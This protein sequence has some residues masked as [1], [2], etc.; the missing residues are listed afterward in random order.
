MAD[1][2]T[3]E[4]IS[5]E[6]FEAGTA[7]I[8]ERDSADG[9]RLL[10]Y[11]PAA[12]EAEVRAAIARAASGARISAAEWIAR[13]DW[14]EQ[15]KSGLKAAE[16][17]PRLL[18]RPSFVDA[19]SKP[20]QTQLIIDP[21][22]AFGTGGHPST[23]LLLEWIDALQPALEARNPNWRMLDVGTGTGVLSLAAVSFGA[24]LAFAFDLD[25]L[26]IA[27]TCAN[28]RANDIESGL[29]V[30]IGPLDAVADETFDLVVANLLRT[31]LMP[32]IDGIAA[33]VRPGGYAVFAGLLHDECESVVAAAR[34]TGLS[35]TG[36]RA[37]A[38]ANGDLWSA[39]LMTR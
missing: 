21:G 32:L 15:W 17:S 3:A 5:A 20:G 36:E 34:A 25:P 22:Q 8:E 39:L 28:A 19:I 23:H 27:A 2:E 16:I 10:L 13:T 37:M 6:V 14:S 33:R 9:I 31:E 18:V 11:V 24:R 35:H 26:A 1:P 12:A 29:E 38:D 7:G 30:F 4:I